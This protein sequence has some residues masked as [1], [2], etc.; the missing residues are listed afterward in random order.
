MVKELVDIVELAECFLDHFCERSVK[1]TK[2]SIMKSSSLFLL[3]REE[4]VHHCFQIY[5]DTEL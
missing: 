5:V 3:N 4:G 2:I 1:N